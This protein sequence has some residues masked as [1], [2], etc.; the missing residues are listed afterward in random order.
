MKQ[1]QSW[2]ALKRWK[3]ALEAAE[4]MKKSLAGNDPASAELDFAAGKPHGPGA[5]R[6]GRAAFE[7]VIDASGKGDL[8][9]HAL[10]MHGE[11]YFHQDKLRGSPRFSQGRHPVQGP[12][13][14]GGRASGSGK[15]L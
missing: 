5:T 7:R 8:G 4:A 2:I 15:S 3:E 12:A 9:A 10:L 6:R 1:I 11:A 14:A 13:L